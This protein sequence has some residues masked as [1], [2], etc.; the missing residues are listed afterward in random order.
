MKRI[1]VIIVLT[2]SAVG[3]A[4]AQNATE[5][6]EISGKVIDKESQK[7]IPQSNIYIK[8]AEIG[9]VANNSGEFILK[10]PGKYFNGVLVWSSMGYTTIE[11]NIEELA[12]G[13]LI[14]QLTPVSVIMNEITIRDAQAILEE[15][16]ER[17]HNNYPSQYQLMTSFYREVIKKNRSYVD[18]SQG[19]LNVSKAPYTDLKG[20]KMSIVKGSR[21]QQYEKEDTMAFK[22]MGGP[23][24]S[25]ILDVVKYPGI[26]L[27][28]ET[29]E[30]YDYLLTGVNIIDGKENF[31]I[32]F[33]PKPEFDEALYS[34]VI[35]VDVSSY[36]VSGISFGY[37]KQN[38]KKAAVQLVKRKPA[39]AKL[40]PKKV[41][42]EVKYRETNGVWYLDY[43]RNEIEMKC[44]WKKR[45]FNST[46]YSVSEMVIT[47]K[48][49]SD[50]EGDIAKSTATKST[51]IF[52]EK[53]GNFKDP[54]FWENYS[55]IKPE[56]DLRKALAKIDNANH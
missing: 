12:E 15:A 30:Y 28:E 10:V 39:F 55:I 45:L 49:L 20:D 3:L 46:F 33:S 41:E 4:T 26:V 29:F 31:V 24:T 48:I 54:N 16:V 44:N 43:V 8:D 53:V 50:T 13:E 27:N 5:F 40:T 23:N 42:Y 11:K 47:Q 17:K 6:K 7:P 2:I 38:L 32:N 9:T 37:D 35:Y 21:S 25:L 22:L 52:S 1:L 51:D 56:D 36:A 18:V 34:G 14:I 19:I